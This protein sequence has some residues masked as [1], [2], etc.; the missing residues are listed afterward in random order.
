MSK[1]LLRTIL[2]ISCFILNYAQAEAYFPDI[3]NQKVLV[4]DFHMHTV[5]SDGFVWP[6]VRVDEARREGIDAIAISDH[7]EYQPHSRDIPT[8][9][10]RPY[11]IALEKA[12]ENNIL[13]IRAAEIT[14]DT[15]PGHYNA[16][17]L[18]D[19][20]PLDTPDFLTVFEKANDQQ[21]FVFWNHHDWQGTQ[22]G[23]W[24]DVQTTLY[25]NHWL[26]GMEVANGSAYYPRAH[27]WCLEKNLTLIGNSD[28]HHPSI[29]FQYTAHKHRTLTLVFARRRTAESIREALNARQT[30]VWHNNQLIGRENVLQP[31]FDA[32]VTVEKPHY[33]KNGY[34]WF[35]MQNHALLDFKLTAEKGTNPAQI[36][37]PSKSEVIVKAKIPED[38]Q[39]LDLS[40]TVTNFLIQ[41]GRGLPVTLSVPLP[42]IP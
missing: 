33:V 23:N 36:H 24:E 10:N 13:L 39:A 31:L 28:I 5:F 6:T 11:E 12:K 3:P 26:H 38:A 9:H 30:A 1:N 21:A 2:L 14:R 16:I 19:I 40:Y 42:S 17:F 34:A 35:E 7:I 25:E 41:P 4:C 15:P 32:C 20:D 37:I 8:Q 18:D 22:R 29:D 27:Q